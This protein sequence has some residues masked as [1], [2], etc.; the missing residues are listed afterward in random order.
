MYDRRGASS[1]ISFRQ[2]HVCGADAI[3]LPRVAHAGLR[4]NPWARCTT[5]LTKSK[6]PHSQFV[7][8]VELW[9]LLSALDGSARHF[10][11]AG[12]PAGR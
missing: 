12:C 8:T 11:T 10:A 7:D 2:R 6:Q 4:T 1:R 9:G 5:W 3:A